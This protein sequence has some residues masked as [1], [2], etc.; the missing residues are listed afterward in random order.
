MVR[1]DHSVVAILSLSLVDKSPDDRQI[2]F[3]F[4]VFIGVYLP[5]LAMKEE[6]QF[7]PSY[8]G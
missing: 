2:W 3:L 8:E 1:E 4:L 6:S 7:L 5:E